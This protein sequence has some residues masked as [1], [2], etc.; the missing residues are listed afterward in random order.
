MTSFLICTFNSISHLLCIYI[1]PVESIPD[2]TKSSK[3]TEGQSGNVWAV[4][5]KCR[6]I[7]YGG[8]LK[9]HQGSLDLH[10]RIYSYLHFKFSFLLFNI[11]LLSCSPSAVCVSVEVMWFLL[12]NL[13]LKSLR[14]SKS[15]WILN[16]NLHLDNSNSSRSNILFISLHI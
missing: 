13:F 10:T 14:R 3:G 2:F 16:I 4:F 5:W 8:L 12:I 15:E 1:I 11:L 6:H 7:Q 9:S